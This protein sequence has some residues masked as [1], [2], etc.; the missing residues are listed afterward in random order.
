MN[1]LRIFGFSLLG[2]IS[3]VYFGFLFILPNVIDLN[4]YKPFVK[5]IAKEQA[6]LNVD[7]ENIKVI[8]TPLLGVGAKIDNVSVKLPDGSILFSADGIKTRVSIPSLLLMTVKISCFEVEKPFINLEIAEDNIDYKVAKLVEDILNSNKEKTLGEDIEE[9]ESWFNPAWI[10]VKVPAAKLNNYKILITDLK[11][12]HYLDLHGEQL[13]AGYFN[14]K[15][16]KLKTY[17][18]L[19]SDTNKNITLNID[20][21]TFL[22]KAEPKLD[23]E[24]DPAERI[25]IPFINSV[26]MYQNY[27]LK[28][29]IDTKLRIN[30][31]RN[32]ITSFGHINIDNISM[33]VSELKL[34]ESYIK[35]NSFGSNL[36]LDTNI[37]AAPE[38]NIQLNGKVN[39]SKHP[40]MNLSI[41]TGKIQFSDMLTLGRAFLDSLR[42]KNE[43]SQFKANGS[44]VADCYI[45][46]NFKKLKSNGFIKIQ[47][48]GIAVRNLGQVIS[49]ANININLDDNV[50]T[51]DNSSLF[52]NNSKVYVNGNIDKKSVAAISVKTEELP[53]PV[54]FNAFA[55]KNIRNAYS[56]KSGNVSLDFV[57]EGKLKDAVAG[58][59]F[60][61]NNLNFADRNNSFGILNNSL[62]GNFICETKKQKIDGKI[63]NDGF[64]LSL[65][66][67]NSSVSLPTLEIGIA[68]KNI[69]IPENKLLF[70]DHSEILFQGD[71]QDYTKLHKIEF[72]TNG[73]IDTNDLI[74]LIG[75]EYKS[76]ID[77]KGTIPVKLN[78]IGDNKKQ[79][80]TA[81][82]LSNN[83]NYITPVE[84]TE[85]GGKTTVLQAIVDFKPSRIKIKKTGLF[86][87]TIT[88]DDKGNKTE[89]LDS[90]ADVDGTI[91]GD[92]INL[93][94]IHFPKN[95]SG[96]IFAFPR[97][98]FLAEKTRLFVFGQT[99]SPLIRGSKSI[100][101]I[102][103]PE[104]L[105]RID[106]VNLNF[107][108][109]DL[110]F[111]LKD[112]VL[113]GSDISV[114]GTMS[115]LA[116]K[117]ININGLDISSR[118]INLEKMLAVADKAQK[119]VPQSTNNQKVSSS[120]AEIPVAVHSGSINMRRIITGNIEL[121]DT[122]ARMTLLRNI[123]GLRNLRT[124]IF[125]GDVHGSINVDLIKLLIAVDLQGQN[126][127]VAKALLDA[128]GMKDMLAGTADFDA[129][130]TID[131]SAKT[132]TEQLK[133]IEGD[134][135]FIVKDGQFG[136]FGKIE[137]LIIAQ[138]I[139]ESQFF[140]T[141]LGGV[142]NSL[143]SIDT[144]HFS[145][146]IGHLTLEQGVCHIDPITSLGT[147]LSLHIFGDFDIVKNYAD[148][149]VRARMSSI[150]SKL[151]G[152]LNAINPINLMNS[153]AS[154]NVVTAK[155][156]ALFCEVVPQEELDNL[157]SFANKY[158]DSGAAK[159]QLKI[160]GDAA[161]PLT[162]VKSFKW[163]T[164][165]S[166]YDDAVAFVNSLPDPVEG[167]TAT[168]IEEAIAEAKAL[169]AEKKTVKYKIKHLFSKKE[170]IKSSENT[171]TED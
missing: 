46:T 150:I 120:P 99:S 66:K 10:R 38:Q 71:I 88:T 49:S 171:N 56:F 160:L 28:A 139:R 167:S 119:Y 95:L 107:R 1:K 3:L 48:G 34:P 124:N 130:L 101:E 24:D 162:L 108:G 164:S 32:E 104:L 27:D 129:K 90:I 154:M 12:K 103:I 7:F 41:K 52:V 121:T 109:H 155:A 115:L 132:Q 69:I 125:K 59:N 65:P 145:E 116:D 89:H 163:L 146:L 102:S 60:N 152:P 64:V 86:I 161:K 17:A 141:A 168:N 23:A 96:R 25:D 80:L 30:Q 143:T 74:K 68:N 50:L 44:I 91:A 151:L 81:R 43:L 11:T 106:S 153:A 5:D 122:N 13:V 82:A 158:V 29:N 77:S 53:L 45:K 31:K 63:I 20:V 85:L 100:K 15:R 47:N 148:M 33:K 73:N 149:K 142:I 4:Q 105:T 97:S 37:Y 128:A 112:I 39:Y 140:Q 118:Y 8:T 135:N 114:N 70:N 18:E 9:K 78:I 117:V 133:G 147:T 169:E 138:N 165:K 87:R 134:I 2:I 156:F 126:I 83:E 93:I 21:N 58:A 79:T 54:I 113:N 166:A 76:Y 72:L 40:N 123:L 6:K 75:R 22:P 170:K 94:K 111:N 16:A 57:L 131:G 110:L 157:P 35:I 14:G 84:F 92:R 51:F 62:K 136:P 42:I 67:T 55:P 19:F 144:T 36:D 137:N 61:L 98:S 26:Q 127:D 159:F